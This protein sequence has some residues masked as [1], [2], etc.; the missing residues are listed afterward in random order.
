MQSWLEELG[1]D[2]ADEL[3]F[4]MIT[5]DPERDT[6]ELLSN[7]MSAFD[8]RI[9]AYTAGVENTP[10]LLKSYRVYS[11]KIYE[12]E[13]N[14]EVYTM[15]H[16]ASVYLLDSDSQFI[17]TIAYAENPDVAVQKLKNLVNR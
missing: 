9:R 1:D 10:E 12:D 7:Y 4:A 17:G 14:K 8:P 3:H 5:V 16:T 2:L 15:D 13:D 6:P 11:K